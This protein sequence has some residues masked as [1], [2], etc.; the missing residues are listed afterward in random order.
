MLTGFSATEPDIRGSTPLSIRAELLSSGFR[1]LNGF[2][3]AEV[4]ER[5]GA[6]P[7]T[8]ADVRNQAATDAQGNPTGQISGANLAVLLVAIVGGVFL[9]QRLLK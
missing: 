7:T 1:A 3:D 8:Q 5:L 4:S 6:T 9:L 2:I